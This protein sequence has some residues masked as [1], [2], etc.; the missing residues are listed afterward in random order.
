[1]TR[2]RIKAERRIRRKGWVVSNLMQPI[3][4]NRGGEGRRWYQE[5][6]MHAGEQHR[7]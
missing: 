6:V 7:G 5:Q 3:V 4:G 2:K 1:M